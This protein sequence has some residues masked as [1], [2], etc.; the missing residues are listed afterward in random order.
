MISETSEEEPEE[1]PPQEEAP[2]DQAPEEQ[3]QEWRI[4]PDLKDNCKVAA[5][6]KMK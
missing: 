3:H 1:E 6:V 5:Y 4:V 2:E